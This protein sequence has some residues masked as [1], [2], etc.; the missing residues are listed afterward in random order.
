[1]TTNRTMDSAVRT[2]LARALTDRSISDADI[3]SV[4]AKVERLSETAEIRRLDKSAYGIWIDYLVPR[5][6]WG[7]VVGGIFGS[8]VVINRFEGFP[9]GLLADDL[10]HLKVEVALDEISGVG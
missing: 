4:T 9:W 2:A 1:M 7:K 3:K 5:E 8:D 10:I 6:E